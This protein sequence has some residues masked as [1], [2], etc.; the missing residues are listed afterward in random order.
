M[1]PRERRIYNALP[2]LLRPF[3]VACLDVRDF[4]RFVRGRVD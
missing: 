3:F 1:S 2:A 4:V